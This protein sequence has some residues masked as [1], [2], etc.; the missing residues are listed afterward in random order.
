MAYTAKLVDGQSYYVQGVN[1]VKN[2]EVEVNKELADYLEENPKFEV[3]KEKSPEDKAEA[4]AKAK[5]KA[6]AKAKKKA[7]DQKKA[8]ENDKKEE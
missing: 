6:E 8:E 7:E 2:K 5:A 1:F 3:K 4:E